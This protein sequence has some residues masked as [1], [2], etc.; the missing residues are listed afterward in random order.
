MEEETALKTGDRFVIRFYSPIETVGGGVVLDACPYKHRR[1]R[2]D[3]L[4][5]MH[6]K[7]TGTVKQRLNQ[8]IL[9]YSPDCTPVKQLAVNASID[10]SDASNALKLLE[11]D[12]EAVNITPD[13]WLHRQYLDTFGKRLTGW[14]DEFHKEFPLKEGMSAEEMRSRMGFSPA[15]SNGMLD[16]YTQKRRIKINEGKVSNYRFK[17]VR[18]TDD[19][20][21]FAQIDALYTENGF[22][23]PSTDD[24]KKAF[25]SEKRFTHV[26]SSMISQKTLVRLDEKHF[27]HKD[28]YEKALNGVKELGETKGEIILGEYRDFLSCSGS[29]LYLFL[30]LLTEAVLHERTEM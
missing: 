17:V 25:A 30:N 2:A 16:Y 11:Q 15:V 14:L 24:I 5:A 8:W 22:Q 27:M 10:W 21:L 3:V 1:N 9:E 28:F 20:A 6:I 26:F 18:H 29:M 23:P 4:E 19:E 7:E 12:G 13:L